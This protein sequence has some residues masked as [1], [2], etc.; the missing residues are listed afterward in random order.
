M[1]LDAGGP[2]LRTD[3]RRI[4]GDGRRRSDAEGRGQGRADDG[5]GPGAVPRLATFVA[6]EILFGCGSL[7]EIGFA[8]LRLGAKRPFLVTDEGLLAAGWP[9]EAIKHLAAVG[10]DPTVWCDLTP[11]PKEREVAAGSERYVEEGCD[12]IVVVGGGS[13]I[14]AAKGV[15][16]VASNGGGILDYEGIDRVVRPLPPIV[17]APSTAG[18][19]SDLSQFA[20]ITD[21]NRRLKATLIG[22]ALVPDI[23]IT[24]P[25]LLVTMPDELAATTGL[26]AVTHAIEAF[27]SRGASFLSD[28]HALAALRLARDSLWPS[29]DEPGDLAAR[30]GMARA[31]MMAGLAFT[32]G[33][34]GAT[35]AISHQ[36]GGALDLPHGM[37]NAVLLPHTMRFNAEEDP[38]QYLPVADALGVPTEGVP[39]EEAVEAAVQ[40]IVELGARLGAPRRLA[41]L[42]VREEDL[43]GYARTALDDACLATNP[44]VVTEDDALAVLRAAL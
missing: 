39:A 32:N 26:D 29:L 1:K 11:N 30:T 12:V 3:R 21:T 18:T 28:Q 36:L 42:G 43:P 41:E 9:D 31:S 24:D 7:A 5:P 38:E 14:D 15:A 20:V 6:P 44:R 27:V 10:L 8:A 22:H 40:A 19:A 33:L 25:R 4:A 17:A 2:G 34:L 37:L 16:V 23:S 13:C 35:H